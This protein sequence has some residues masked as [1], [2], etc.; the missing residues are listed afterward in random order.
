MPKPKILIVDDEERVR[1]AIRD[2]LELQDY[3][4]V[5]ANGCAAA[6]EIFRDAH[7]DGAVLDYRLPDG[8]ALELLPRL[9]AIDPDLPVVILTGQGTIDLAVRAIQEG[10]D[11][12]LVKP[13]ELPAL[14]VLLQRLLERE[15]TH[16]RDLAGEAG[17]G[18]GEDPF[19][20]ESPAVR[21]LAEQAQKMAEVESPVLILGETGTGKGVLARWLHQ[22]SPRAQEAFVDLNCAS[23]SRELLESELFGY[24]K[25]AFTGAAANKL[26]LLEVAHRGTVFLDEIGDVDPLV[27][28]KLLTV[29][30]EKRFR[31]LGDVR[32]RR[33]DLR[34]IA[35]TSRDLG[36]LAQ[37]QRFRSDLYFR[38][39]TLVLRVAPLRERRE[40]IPRFAAELLERLA[41]ERGRRSATLSA[42]AL[43]ALQAYPWPGNVRELRNVLERAV[44]LSSS[45]VL[46]P[47]DLHFEALPAVAASLPHDATTPDDTLTLAELERRHI[48]RVL[49]EASGR[50]AEAAARLG[51]P[52]S[53][54]YQKIKALRVEVSKS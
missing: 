20:G 8:N 4:V 45:S 46:D 54:L 27:Q 11:Q 28:P 24:A 37:E 52:R 21:R 43:A 44:L 10:A 51:I 29:L 26:G 18:R 7:P 5:E 6:E 19:L 50:V 53:T 3:D 14:V 30:E 40:D 42:A 25:G 13:V 17:R 23:L 32:D 36:R 34:L 15:R 38:I 39:S 33:V 12:F 1:F 35:A 41:L 47:A 31:R 22:H 48:E 2:F 16:R 9:K 49:R